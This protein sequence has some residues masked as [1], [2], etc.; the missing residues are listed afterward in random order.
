MGEVPSLAEDAIDVSAMAIHWRMPKSWRCGKPQNAMVRMLGILRIAHLWSRS[1]RVRCAPDQ[2]Y[3]RTSGVSFSGP[4]TRN[5]VLAVRFGT[6]RVTLIL[7]PARKPL[8]V[9]A[10]MNVRNCSQISSLKDGSETNGERLPRIVSKTWF[11]M[12]VRDDIRGHSGQRFTGPSFRCI[13][14]YTG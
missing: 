13:C 1:S 14:A 8:V 2:R 6:S 5:S 3:K 10:S 12:N 9:C 7:A 4:G 11:R